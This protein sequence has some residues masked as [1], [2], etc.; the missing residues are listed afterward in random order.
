MEPQHVEIRHTF[1]KFFV[2]YILV[3]KLQKYNMCNHRVDGAS[4]TV[5][6][7]SV[8]RL[9]AEATGMLGHGEQSFTQ[10]VVSSTI[11]VYI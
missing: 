2:K 10:A 11:F 4:Y 8:W 3:Q 5:T 9:T 1:Q 7:V 6:P